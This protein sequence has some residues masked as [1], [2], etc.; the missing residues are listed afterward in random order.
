[1]EFFLSNF[2][3]L[4][5]FILAQ[6]SSLDRFSLWFKFLLKVCLLR[7]WLIRGQKSLFKYFHTFTSDL[8][9]CI[10]AAYLSLE[11]VFILRRQTVVKDVPCEYSDSTHRLRKFITSI[12]AYFFMTV[13]IIFLIEIISSLSSLLPLARLIWAIFLHF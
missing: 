12:L 4:L 9:W 6:W 3:V 5:C 13:F 11:I 10:S 1:M 7:H 2:W 8:F